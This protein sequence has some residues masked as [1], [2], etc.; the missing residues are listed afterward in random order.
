MSVDAGELATKWISKGLKKS[1]RNILKHSDDLEKE[2]IKLVNNAKKIEIKHTGK[3][4]K[5][6]ID[7]N[8]IPKQKFK[9]STLTHNH[10][11]GS[12]LSLKDVKL[13]IKTELREIRA[14]TP[15]GTVYSMK[16][17]KISV[18]KNRELLRFI[19][20]EEEIVQIEYKDLGKYYQDAIVFQKVYNEMKDLIEYT[21]YIN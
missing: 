16:N 10:P 2:I 7:W 19:K 15:N 6:S 18:K 8:H 11:S 9:G 17:I 3:K 14:V 21:H 5:S 20:K 12:G 4:Y 1:A 13:F